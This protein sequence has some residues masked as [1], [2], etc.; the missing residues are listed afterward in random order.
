MNIA[1]ARINETLEKLDNA[2][3]RAAAEAVSFPVRLR[4]PHL[5]F[6]V[7]DAMWAVRQDI[8]EQLEPQ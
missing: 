4:A 6:D 7:A 1:A 2:L 5:A 3:W 8:R